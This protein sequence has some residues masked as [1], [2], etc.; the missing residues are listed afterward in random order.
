MNLKSFFGGWNKSNRT[1]KNKSKKNRTKKVNCG[2]KK[3]NK[4]K[5]KRN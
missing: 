5:S 4:N 2:V 1:K 3:Q